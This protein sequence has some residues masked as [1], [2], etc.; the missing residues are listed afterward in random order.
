[1]DLRGFLARER[2]RVEEALANALGILLPKVPGEFGPALRH[3]VLSGGKRLRPIL[4]V[5]A[6][7]APKRHFS[8]NTAALADELC[9]LSCMGRGRASPARMKN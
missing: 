2:D 9:Q 4:C 6:Y 1:M 5:A 3:G 7:R 8:G